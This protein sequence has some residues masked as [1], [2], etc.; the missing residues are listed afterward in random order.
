VNDTA[1]AATNQSPISQEESQSSKSKTP[2]VSQQKRWT[3]YNDMGSPD[4]SVNDGRKNLQQYQSL[5]PCAWTLKYNSPITD[6]QPLGEPLSETN[7]PPTGDSLS[8]DETEVP[9][10]YIFVP[11]DG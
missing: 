10:S 4:V 3:V 2:T 6:G 8:V 11:Y 7:S 1:T 5:S 9:S